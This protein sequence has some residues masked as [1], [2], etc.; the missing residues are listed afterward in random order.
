MMSAFGKLKALVTK[1]LEGPFLYPFLG[2]EA[3]D[4]ATIPTG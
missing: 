3:A 4:R 2:K 1:K